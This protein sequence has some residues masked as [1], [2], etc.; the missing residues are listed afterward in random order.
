MIKRIKIANKWQGKKNVPAFQISGEYLREHGF[1]IGDEVQV[2]MFRDEIRIVKM[3][4]E[5]ILN[6]LRTGN[7]E[8]N[9][10]IGFLCCGD[11]D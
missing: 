9:K 10:Y 4:P 1:S 5:M 2:Q 3:T 11:C 7:K 6:D 8:M